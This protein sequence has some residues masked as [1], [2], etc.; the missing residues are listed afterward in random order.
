MVYEEKYLKRHHFKIIVI[1]MDTLRG[2]IPHN[3][4]PLLDISLNKKMNG[5]SL[6]ISN[7]SKLSK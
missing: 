2:L 6:Y 7:D 4:D 1:S 3:N 5:I